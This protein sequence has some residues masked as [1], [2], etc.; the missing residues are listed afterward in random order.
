MRNRKF[1]YNPLSDNVS[2]NEINAYIQQKLPSFLEKVESNPPVKSALF[3]MF[4]AKNIQDLSSKMQ[5]LLPNVVKKQI[6]SLEKKV[7]ELAVQMA[8]LE[9]QNQYG[10]DIKSE[11]YA[12]FNLPVPNP[13]RSG[14]GRRYRNR[15]NPPSSRGVLVYLSE[16]ERDIMREDKFPMKF[17]ESNRVNLKDINQLINLVIRAKNEN[18]EYLDPYEMRNDKKERI[19]SDILQKIKA[20]Y[21]QYDDIPFEYGE[22]IDHREV[23]KIFGAGGRRGAMAMNRP[24]HMGINLFEFR[25]KSIEKVI[26]DRQIEMVLNKMLKKVIGYGYDPMELDI[27]SLRGNHWVDDNGY[28]KVS[29]DFIEDDEGNPIMALFEYTP[30]GTLL[31]V[32]LIVQDEYYDNRRN[33]KKYF[34]SFNKFEQEDI[35]N[36][37]FDENSVDLTK[38][39]YSKEELEHIL[40]EV[41]SM[42]PSAF[43]S[44]D[45]IS[46]RD[47]AYIKSLE[48]ISN[49]IQRALIEGEMRDR[50]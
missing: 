29:V 39:V 38:N 28:V 5:M 46:S 32:S 48:K 13:R 22:I 23:N 6:D 45:S 43:G 47:P 16:Q 10:V 4:G 30:Q 11:L 3:G 15:K 25:N 8:V 35:K 40:R 37:L 42:L 17:T 1:R 2:D 34:I 49:K 50:F 33:P 20:T 31:K 12:R 27:E 44:F 36:A 26:Q 7:T 19:Y 24:R 21:P 18:A 14:R 9:A 41:T